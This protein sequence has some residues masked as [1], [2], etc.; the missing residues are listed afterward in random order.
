VAAVP[1]YVSDKH[2]G[3][4]S[5]KPFHKTHHPGA[6]VEGVRLDETL[7]HLHIED[8]TVLKI[9]IEG[10]D[11]L[12]L[13]SF[14]FEHMRPDVVMCEFMDS[15]S[16]KHFG[17][18]HHDM[19]HYMQARGYT[20]FVAEWAPVRSYASIGGPTQHV[21]RRCMRYPLSRPP[22]WGNLLCVPADQAASFEATLHNYL[23]D[24]RT[25]NQ[26]V[27]NRRKRER[28]ERIKAVLAHIVP[29]GKLS[30]YT[31]VRVFRTVFQQ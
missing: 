28:R 14:D 13:K 31:I 19:A 24:I 30:L 7:H 16:Q 6:A 22:A 1:F 26:G 18:T 9:D 2:P 11:F 3:I 10:A 25:H 20:V 27:Y 8:I 5:L 12:A 29:G 21:F 4:H 23:N 15:R 17:Y